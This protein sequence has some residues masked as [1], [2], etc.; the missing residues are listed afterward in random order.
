MMNSYT[1][2][3]RNVIVTCISLFAL[4]SILAFSADNIEKIRKN[5]TKTEVHNIL[6]KPSTVVNQGTLAGKTVEVWKYG[7]DTEINFVDGKVESVLTTKT[8]P[9]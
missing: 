6:G 5:M 9:K 2:M 7:T 3:K 4:V 8:T 1:A